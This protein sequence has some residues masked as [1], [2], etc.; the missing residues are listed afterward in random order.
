MHSLGP[1]HEA[2]A[3]D[4]PVVLVGSPGLITQDGLESEVELVFVQ[5]V[6]TVAEESVDP[7][8]VISSISVLVMLNHPKPVFKVVDVQSWVQGVSAGVKGIDSCWSSASV[9]LASQVLEELSFGETTV[10]SSCLVHSSLQ[11]SPELVKFGLKSKCEGTNHRRLTILYFT[12][13]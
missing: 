2:H 4:V 1:G 3:V 5:L 6:K 11:L 13:N 12:I 10:S 9:L 7:V 8:S